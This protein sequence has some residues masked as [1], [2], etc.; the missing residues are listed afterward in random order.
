[1]TASS[2]EGRFGDA[3]RWAALDLIRRGLA[4]SIDSDAHD[5]VHRDPDMNYGIEAARAVMPELD[6]LVDSLTRTV[7]AEILGRD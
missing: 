5:A 1:V 6:V 4:H 2:L 3:A 7:P